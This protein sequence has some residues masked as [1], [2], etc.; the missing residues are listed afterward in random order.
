MV[1]DALVSFAVQ[2]S[3]ATLTLNDPTR[4]NPLSLPLI[5]ACLEA[6]KRVQGDATIRVLVLAAHGRGFCAGADLADLAERAARGA[7]AERAAEA[8]PVAQPDQGRLAEHGPMQPSLGE[9]VA[10]VVTTGGN[11][12]VLALRN[13]PV[14]VVA[15]VHGPVA[16][17]GVGLA[18]AAD[19]VVAARSA[20][21]YLPFVPALGLIPDMGAAWFMHRAIGPARAAA[22]ALLG[23]KLGADQA[24]QWGLIWACVDDAALDAEVE[25]ITSR[26]AALPA[27]AI[28]EMRALWRGLEGRTLA[29]QLAHEC[30][31]QREL[32]DGPAFAEGLR[33]FI[34]KRQPRFAGRG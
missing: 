14:P 18:L 17:G 27:H 5:Q 9:Q 8:G 20:Y 34:E 23:D 13:L 21:F 6:L 3:V 10:H 24:A 4:L 31:R 26:L 16:G 28:G 2:G 32:I 29:E 33:A 7:N 12:L 25:R 30:T 15:R 22:L 1:N 11:P 19:I